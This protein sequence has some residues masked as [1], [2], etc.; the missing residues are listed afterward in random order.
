MAWKPISVSSDG[1]L[2]VGHE[3]Y[4][5]VVADTCVGLWETPDKYRL[6]YK[7]SK[8]IEILKSNCDDIYSRK[9]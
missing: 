6:T 2:V 5:G 4:G 1:V 3:H 8:A 9:F 7:D